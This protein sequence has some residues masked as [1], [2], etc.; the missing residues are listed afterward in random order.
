MSTLMTQDSGSTAVPTANGTID[1][2]QKYTV[3][4][5]RNVHAHV[6]RPRPGPTVAALKGVSVEI[7]RDAEVT[8]NGQAPRG[9]TRT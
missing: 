3:T 6:P 8:L 2:G 7:A 1:M 5:K 9:L 4:V